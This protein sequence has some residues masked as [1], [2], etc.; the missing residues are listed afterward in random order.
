MAEPRACGVHLCGKV[1]ADLRAD[2]G[3]DSI[4]R[5]AADRQLVCEAGLCASGLEDVRDLRK[6]VSCG[7]GVSCGTPCSAVGFA[8]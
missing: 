8:E 1:R 2:L 3:A 4:C 7:K 5:G 6:A